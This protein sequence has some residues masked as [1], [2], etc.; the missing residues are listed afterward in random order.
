MIKDP[1]FF[2]D[3]V[4]IKVAG[5]DQNKAKRQQKG[6]ETTKL[7]NKMTSKFNLPM[8][9][10]KVSVVCKDH[11]SE[12]KICWCEDSNESKK[13]IQCDHCKMWYHCNCVGISKSEA[14]ENAVF[15]CKKCIDWA[16][17]KKAIILPAI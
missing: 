7:G 6:K 15:S 11:R 16:E 14:N 17:H 1:A 9:G 4:S 8:R 3:E 5:A 10:G 2:L 13:L 12:L